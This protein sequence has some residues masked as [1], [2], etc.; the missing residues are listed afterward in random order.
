[1]Q[2]QIGIKGLKMGWYKFAQL[3]A[4]KCSPVNLKKLLQFA[5]TPGQAYLFEMGEEHSAMQKHIERL[6]GKRYKI[7]FLLN[8][9]DAMLTDL[10]DTKLDFEVDQ[11]RIA[12]R[13]DSDY[14]EESY[15]YIFDEDDTKFWEN[16]DGINDQVLE[17]I[18]DSWDVSE[19]DFE[20]RL[21]NYPISSR[22][23]NNSKEL[24]SLKD[25]SEE[26]SSFA[27]FGDMISCIGNLKHDK[28]VARDIMREIADIDIDLRS[29]GESATG[30]HVHTWAKNK[31][32]DLTLAVVQKAA[33][34]EQNVEI[35]KYDPDSAK[36]IAQKAY[37]NV[38]NSWV[39]SIEKLPHS[40]TD[41]EKA[42][43]EAFR[44]QVKES[45]WESN[46]QRF[47]ED[48]VDSEI[49]STADSFNYDDR[50]WAKNTLPAE[51]VDPNV[52]HHV[53]KTFTEALK[54]HNWLDREEDS[55]H[56]QVE[57]SSYFANLGV[58][59]WSKIADDIQ[60]MA[61]NHA[62]TGYEDYVKEIRSYTSMI[63]WIVASDPDLSAIFSDED[64]DPT[65]LTQTATDLGQIVKTSYEVISLMPQDDARRM[66]QSITAENPE[67]EDWI[68]ALREREE[69]ER[70]ARETQAAMLAEEEARKAIQRSSRERIEKEVSEESKKINDPN[71][72]SRS[73]TEEQ[74][75][76]AKTQNIIGKPFEHMSTLRVDQKYPGVSAFVLKP[77]PMESEVP[78][79]TFH[80]AIYPK[81]EQS[82]PTRLHDV[83]DR[84]TGLNF[85][86]FSFPEHVNENYY[87]L[88]GWVGGTIDLYNKIMYVTEIQSDVMQNTPRMK[89][90]SKSIVALNEGK[91]SL[92]AEA[93]KIK[94]YITTND[95]NAYYDKRIQD[96]KLKIQSMSDSPAAMQMQQAVLK[97]EELKNKGVDPFE[98]E[99]QKL[100]DI[101]NKLKEINRQIND[102][103][104]FDKKPSAKLNKPHL[105]E[106]R[107]RIENRF[108]DWVD[109]F[110]NEIFMYCSRLGIK[111]LY[112]AAS[113]YL[114]LTWRQYAKASTL[115]LY[116]K[117]YDTKAEKYGMRKVHYK[118]VTYWHLDLSEN[119]PKFASKERLQMSKNNWYR[120]IKTA[121]DFSSIY[122]D[123][124]KRKFSNGEIT[125]EQMQAQI[126][127]RY[128]EHTQD[129]TT[130]DPKLF[131]IEA[132]TFFDTIKH[133][134]GRER[135]GEDSE[136]SKAQFMREALGQF[137]EFNGKKYTDRDGKLEEPFKSILQRLL[138]QKFNYDMD[139]DEMVE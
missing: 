50:R 49:E 40:K 8:T 66:E 34:G 39:D 35:A 112:I 113:S 13:I 7:Q 108:T 138:I 78:Y 124:I 128:M 111:H 132:K 69:V 45:W 4:M 126:R 22:E 103:E 6:G 3:H 79:K 92:L 20:S 58:K 91:N 52:R 125:E 59:D 33:G 36:Q 77:V 63:N 136:F 93:E 75:Q 1:M 117:I 73:F 31:G 46:K 130:R 27:Y 60:E 5:H 76:Q 139:L 11:D 74:K 94:T 87:D 67:I 62:M 81:K 17:F 71:I 30:I 15:G 23:P 107:S 129:P 26:L 19:D 25:I 109:T 54:E 105:S 18:E 70:Q 85:H 47:M 95:I 80:I 28:Y 86:G 89:D 9:F 115:E 14:V 101:D 43:E 122:I 133:I 110:Y 64:A 68:K 96:L 84:S 104:E 51:S 119:M 37:S 61:D 2:S 100:H 12:N 98:K 97:L 116:K 72:G 137:L 114:Y 82:D 38:A 90:V 41:L 21:F 134:E 24:V 44:D 83:F 53:S 57:D 99:R 48:A 121:M 131:I 65:T 10:D 123:D 16:I 106:L 56:V 135:G 102:I 127:E 29:M 32:I 118:G 42:I 55:G 120:Q 88:I